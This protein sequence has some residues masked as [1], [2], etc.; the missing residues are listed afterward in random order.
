VTGYLVAEEILELAQVGGKAFSEPVAEFARDRGVAN[1]RSPS[2]QESSQPGSLVGS[3]SRIELDLA[4]RQPR[5]V[6]QAR[7]GLVN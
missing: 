6:V 1:A 4:S 2:R 5:E 7:D 3:P